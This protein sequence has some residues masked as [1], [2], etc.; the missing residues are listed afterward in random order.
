[1]RTVRLVRDAR[2]P[3]YFTRIVL[4]DVMLVLAARPAMLLNNVSSFLGM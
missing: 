2:S 3:T 4:G 1:M